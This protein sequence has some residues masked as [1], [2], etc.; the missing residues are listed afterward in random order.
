MA[1]TLPKNVLEKSAASGED[2]PMT[3]R[4]QMRL[5]EL[6]QE[7]GLSITTVSRALGGYSDVAAATRERVRE[8]AERHGYVPSRLGRMLV[9]GR[10]DFIGMVLPIRE[11]RMIDAFVGAFVAGL[12]EGLA[13]KGRDLFIGAVPDSRS[14]LDVIKHIVD[15]AR[16]D[17]LVLFR[18]EADDERV[19][20][21]LDRNFP[22]V[23]HGRA[24][25]EARPYVWFDTD[26]ERA[27]AEAARLLLKLG[28][29]QFAMLVAAEPYTYSMLRRRGAERALADAGVQLAADSIIEV[30][31]SDAA[32]PRQAAG[33]ALS[34]VP[35]PTAVL[36]V[37]DALALALLDAAR[38]TSIRV[39]DDLSVI[40][41]DDA[42]VSAYA[43]PPLSTFENRARQSA[44]FV[45]G[46]AVALLEEG[47]AE[48]R[49]VMP[50]FVPRG[51]HGPAAAGS[52]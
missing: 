45:A 23:C 19:R 43:S 11:G 26:G 37:T 9:S 49:L 14:E 50:D 21:L 3:G 25:N 30:A 34:L 38:E 8:A 41:F 28:H 10:T 33:R 32:A 24:L 5:K 52:R 2:A 13:A 27:F 40:G 44:N 35:R 15:G 4:R 1:I 20:F 7:L 16:A 29:R 12:S 51:S 18:T 17:A 31:M 46:M 22:F 36:C 42:P 6:S 47:S 39:P 48:N